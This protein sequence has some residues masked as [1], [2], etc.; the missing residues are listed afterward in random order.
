MVFNTTFNNISGN[1][2]TQRKTSDKVTDKLYHLRI[3][4][5]FCSVHEEITSIRLYTPGYARVI[6]S[7]DAK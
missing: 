2:S 3:D 1:C 5:N 6:C 7:L 4:R